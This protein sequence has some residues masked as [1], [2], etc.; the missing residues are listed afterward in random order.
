M[1]VL[2]RKRYCTIKEF[3]EYWKISRTQVYRFMQM[4]GFPYK[5]VGGTIR[6]SFDE[7]NEWIDKTFN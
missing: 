4:D 7:A 1:P 5:R 2:T 3:C 6:I